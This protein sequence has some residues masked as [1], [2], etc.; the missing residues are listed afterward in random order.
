[1]FVL[2]LNFAVIGCE[3]KTSNN[4]KAETQ[5]TSSS[6]DQKEA[7]PQ[8][9]IVLTVNDRPIYK[10]DIGS[11]NMQNIIE[12]EV[13]YE[14]ALSQKKDEDPELIKILETHKKNMIVGRFKGKII[15]SH[16]S[17]IDKVSEEELQKFYQDNK[18]KYTFLNLD[19]I[20]VQERDTANEIY[21]KLEK[22]NKIEDIKEEYSNENIDVR[23]TQINNTKNYNRLFK[24]FEQ[25]EFS[26]SQKENMA[27]TIYIIT[28]VNLPEFNRMKRILKHAYMNQQR[29]IAIKEFVEESIKENNIR[30]NKFPAK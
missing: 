8:E 14:V 9:E 27:Y 16:I 12:D 26:K 5:N 20:S 13:I 28:D 1:M 6:I 17:E 18:G 22:D 21:S 4:E 7:K 11:R 15:K 23:I 29:N 10:S 2:L 24:N 19:K 30:I 25:G 3:N